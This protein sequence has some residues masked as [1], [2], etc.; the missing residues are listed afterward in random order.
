LGIV[1]VHPGSFYCEE[2]GNNRKERRC[3]AQLRKESER[4]KVFLRETAEAVGGYTHPGAIQMVI[5]RKELLKGQNG[6]F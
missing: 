6:S 1:G 4:A 5:K 3:A 2:C